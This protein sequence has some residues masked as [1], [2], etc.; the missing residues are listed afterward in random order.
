MAPGFA[1]PG[2]SWLAPGLLHCRTPKVVS[3][4]VDN[5]YIAN[6]MS[7]RVIDSHTAGEPTRVVLSGGPD[8]LILHPE[9]PFRAGIPS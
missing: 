8:Q 2:D 9:D 6:V 7:I 5:R 1:P 4:I 3:T